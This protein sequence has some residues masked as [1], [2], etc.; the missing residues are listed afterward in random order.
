MNFQPIALFDLKPVDP[1][2]NRKKFRGQE[3]VTILNDRINISAKMYEKLG[4]PAAVEFVT[5]AA[6]NII[7]IRAAEDGSK[8]ALPVY[9]R[10][11][12][13]TINSSYLPGALNLKKINLNSRYVILNDPWKDSGY[14]LFDADKAYIQK[15]KNTKRS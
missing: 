8:Y 10:R 5:D 14:Y 12:G 4:K 9:N 6:K 13:I 1:A 3:T 15:K 2:E 11:S 7:G